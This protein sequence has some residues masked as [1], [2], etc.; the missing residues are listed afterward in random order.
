M[1]LT[2]NSIGLSEAQRTLAEG[3]SS[4][5]LNAAMATALTRTALDIREEVKREMRAVFDRPTR[6]TLDAVYVNPALGS[7]P[8]PGALFGEGLKRRG[9]RAKFLEAEVELKDDFG[10]TEPYLRAQVTGGQRRL[11]GLEV[12]LKAANILPAGWLA[13]PGKD[14]R[15][16]AYGNVSSGVVRQVLSQLRLARLEGDKTNLSFDARKQINA[17]RKAGGRFFA[18]KPGAKS[19]LPPGVYQREF[20]VREASLIFLFVA[21]A[22][23]RK[24]LD[25]YGIANRI[26]RERLPVQMQRAI[27]DHLA[28]VAAKGA[29]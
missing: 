6:F 13:V 17:Q 4:R 24:R 20:F 22:T 2:L 25:F 3:L 27:Q 21:S 26:A 15:R 9:S 5:R 1:K 23:Y 11:K 29:A 12:A 19:K 8:V 7:Q 10:Y 18:V 14:T 28:R 16:D